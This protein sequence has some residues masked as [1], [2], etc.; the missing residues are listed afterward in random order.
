M[1]SFLYKLGV[2]ALG[3]TVGSSLAGW[4]FDRWNLTR[5][6]INPPSRL[7]I[8]RSHLISRAM[9]IQNL[10]R[11]SEFDVLVIGG[12]PM[13]AGCA[14]DAVTR[15]LKTALVEADD[16]AS[17][18]SSKSAST[19]LMEDGAQCLQ[20]AMTES[21]YKKQCSIVK[22]VLREKA[23]L[24][25]SAPHLVHPLPI[26]LPVY[27]WWQIPL[28]W[29]GTKC[30]DLAAGDR[31]VKGSYFLS[32][33]DALELFP[34]LKKDKLVGAI[35]YYDGQD[36]DARMCLAVVVT[37]ARHGATVCNHVEV[38]K[39]LK[40]DDGKGGYVLYGVE[41]IDHMS[42]KKFI[43]KAKCVVNATGSFNNSIRKMDDPTISICD[44]SSCAHIVLP[45]YYSPEQMGL[46]DPFT[47]ED[48]VI[49][50]LPWQMHTIDGTTDTPHVVKEKPA[51]SDDGVQYILNEIQDYVN[52]DV[53]VT[54]DDVLSVWSDIPPSPTTPSVVSQPKKDDTQLWTHN[55]TIHISPS[56]LITVAG[57]K[58]TTS[59]ARAE[60]VI[61][62]AVEVC[63]LKPWSKSIR[64]TLKIENGQNWSPTMY[65]RLVQ[66]YGLEYEVAQHLAKLYGDRAFE[67]AKMASLTGKRWPIAGNRIHPD[68]PCIDAEVRYGVR[69]YACNAVDMI[70]RRLRLSYLNV[71]AAQESLPRIC[72]I[73]AEE[74]NWSNE[75]KKK[76]IKKAKQYL[77]LEMGQATKRNRAK[78]QMYLNLSK[79]EKELC[80]KR[81]ERLDRDEKHS[82]GF[83]QGFGD[84]DF[85]DDILKDIDVNVIGD[86]LKIKRHC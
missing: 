52:S 46:L 63:D 84:C 67:V 74:L 51:P 76:Q 75:E 44:P 69:E 79:E 61:D 32:K 71:Q 42:G 66:G 81:F 27:E 45:G 59:R 37:A 18:T 13:G 5:K 62:T 78:H 21:D 16:F 10:Q 64:N 72:D 35:V 65:A 57:D 25:E 48:R 83:K 39:L 14:L 3:T 70:A 38:L 68:F 49:F 1:A 82:R 29:V 85:S 33:R 17:G 58:V 30:Y 31:N 2:A 22:E 50:F 34:T 77:A 40:K 56:N 12:G 8:H 86:Y 20:K 60:R 47:S 6:V 36:D 19:K 28:Y 55:H 53:D 11:E 15:G 4:T 7:P 24:S 43:I 41:V 23:S 80:A 54:H 26:M 73:M 9:Q